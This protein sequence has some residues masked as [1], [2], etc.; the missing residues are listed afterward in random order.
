MN[1]FLYDISLHHQES[2]MNK[3]H[4]KRE[5]IKG[6]KAQKHIVRRRYTIRQSYPFP[7]MPMGE[8]EQKH[9][10]KRKIGHRGRM[11]VSINAKGGDLWIID[12][13]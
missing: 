1:D 13:H 2:P 6:E 3:M 11:G 7:V 8:K 4:L 12:Y 5:R 10:D 9:A